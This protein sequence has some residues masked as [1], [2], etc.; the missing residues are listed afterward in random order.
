MKRSLAAILFAM[1][2]AAFATPGFA[3]DDEGDDDD[4]ARGPDREI[5]KIVN[6]VEAE[7]IQETVERLEAFGT[8]Q[9]C[10]DTQAPG[11]GITP[12]RDWIFKRF[13]H[14]KGLQVAL[15]PYVHAN[16]PPLLNDLTKTTTFN[17]LAWLPGTTHPER[18]VVIGG[19]YDSRTISVLDTTSDAPGANDSG[20]QSSVVLELA[21]VLS[22]ERHANTIVFVTFSGEEQGLFGSGTIAA[23]MASASKAGLPA[24]FQGAQ[25]VAMLNNDITGGDNFVNGPAELAKFRLYAAG[26]PRETSSRAPDG[27]TDNTSPAR[28]LM[29]FIA[30]WGTPYVPGFDM[31]TKLRNDR[32][33]RSSDQRSFTDNAIPAVRFM[34]TVEC[35][36]SPIDNA[37]CTL[38]ANGL[39]TVTNPSPLSLL[40][41][42][43]P[44][45]TCLLGFAPGDPTTG[46]IA[47]QHSQL[48]RA[49]FVTAEYTARITKVMAATAASLAR[50]PLAP[51]FPKDAAGALVVP[52][53]NAAGAVT[54]SWQSTDRVD[55]FVI[56]ARAVTPLNAVAEN[57]YGPRVRVGGK[58][59]SAT[60]TPAQL[61]LTAGK[62]FF[63]SVA[64]VDAKGHESL[65][66]YP[67]FRCTGTSCAV[68]QN[69]LNVTASR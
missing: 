8:R 51:A 60:V 14:I 26:T 45:R 16:C 53:V 2:L 66:A 23:K 64:A 42:A 50:A 11:R 1:A 62:T 46:L 37:G 52:T 47:H 67:E 18:L 40:P 44:R 59:T 21:K 4:E 5:A 36:P 63:I 10:S 17:V 20:S 43:D 33:G 65:F 69:A 56:A 41:A 68:P 9:S 34:E 25:V 57:F 31:I 61:G 27:T 28:G 15:D 12:A 7:R 35:S 13:S 29:R 38:A 54:L 55:H 22:H 32:P 48:D 30:T 6:R 49:E 24:F 58:A 3:R 39:C 19:H